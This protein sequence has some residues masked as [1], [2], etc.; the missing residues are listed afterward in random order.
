M[1]TEQTTKEQVAESASEQST[2]EPEQA[3]PE[4][5]T[6]TATTETEAA[7]TP[8][9][10]VAPEP[11]PET[12][13]EP[14]PLTFE[15][16]D[17]VNAFIE[18]TPGVKSLFTKAQNDARN[19]GKQAEERRNRQEVGRSANIAQLFESIR[20][21]DS[22]DEKAKAIIGANMGYA[23]TQWAD[24]YPKVLLKSY[25]IPVEVRET[26]MSA[27]EKGDYDR[28]VTT[29]SDGAIESEVTRRVAEERTKIAAEFET[30]LAA[31]MT[32]RGLEAAPASSAPPSVP[33]GRSG[34]G[35][36]L[37]RKQMRNMTPQQLIDTPIEERNAALKADQN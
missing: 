19:E 17:E 22:S 31:E 3:S 6:Q 5:A 32:A 26:A 37:T 33:A 7:S 16:D 29:L 34:S 1:V 21:L 18:R 15:S 27:L 25:E 4:T 23:A 14:T 2:A 30:K 8:E 12:P 35:G 13:S 24:E 28:Y 9:S 36:T 10:E 11:Q 20:D